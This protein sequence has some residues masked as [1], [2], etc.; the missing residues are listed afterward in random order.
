LRGTLHGGDVLVYRSVESLERFLW[1][2]LFV[3]IADINAGLLKSINER[4]ISSNIG[5][6]L[7]ENVAHLGI[8]G[9]WFPLVSLGPWHGVSI[10]P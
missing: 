6:G 5:H 4:R 3:L 10:N 8:G 2:A 1:Q 9:L 7:N